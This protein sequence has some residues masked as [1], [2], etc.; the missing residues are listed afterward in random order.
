MMAKKP[1]YVVFLSRKLDLSIPH[2]IG[3]LQT[4]DLT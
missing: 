4:L 3:N 2:V 1:Q